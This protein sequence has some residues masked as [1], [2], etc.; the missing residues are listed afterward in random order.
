MVN[1]ELFTDGHKAYDY[2]NRVS[3]GKQAKCPKLFLSVVAE[4]SASQRCCGSSSCKGMGGGPMGG[5]VPFLLRKPIHERQTQGV[6][7]LEKMK[8]VQK[9]CGAERRTS[10]II[11]TLRKTQSLDEA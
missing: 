9:N 1:S 6:E 10:N 4:V 5:S 11:T 7:G 8:E 3:F 2:G